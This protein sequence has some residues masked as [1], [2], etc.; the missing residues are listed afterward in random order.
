MEDLRLV[1]DRCVQKLRAGGLTEADL[2][3]AVRIAEKP[4]TQSLLYIQAS[5]T[6]PRSRVIGISI[7]EDGKDPDG[8]DAAG[9][10]LYKTLG[11][12]VAD[13]WRIVK[14]PELTPGLHD[15][16]TLGLGCEYILERWR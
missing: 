1:L 6:N 13:G 4:R 10:F 7:F 2:Q 8:V 9:A 11:D 16:D 14:F 3:E 12:A 5:S 15:Q